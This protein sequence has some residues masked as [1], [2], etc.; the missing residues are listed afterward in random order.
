MVGAH[1]GPGQRNQTEE[2]GE[3]KKKVKFSISVRL[4]FSELIAW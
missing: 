1:E 2:E 3:G 4:A